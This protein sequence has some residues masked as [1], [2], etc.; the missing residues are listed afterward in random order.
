METNPPIVGNLQDLW[1]FP[2][3]GGR[4]GDFDP[5]NSSRDGCLMVDLDATW[6][7]SVLQRM[8]K[9]LAINQEDT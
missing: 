9:M 2:F 5:V 4:V 7:E 3:E 1:S 8:A 6:T